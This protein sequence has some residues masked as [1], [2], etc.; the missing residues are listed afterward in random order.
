V[1]RLRRYTYAV[2]VLR[3]SC[4]TVWVDVRL[5]EIGGRWIASADTPEGPSL[6]LGNGAVE[7][8]EAAL[9]P[10]EGIVDDLMASLADSPLTWP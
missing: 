1:A 2:I 8:I 7:A 3:L 4:A 5:R 9:Q 6:G 10:F